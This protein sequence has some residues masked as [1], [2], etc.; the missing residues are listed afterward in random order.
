MSETPEPIIYQVK[1]VLL[2][3]SPM[4]WRR[5]LVCGDSTITDLHF[6]LQI[7]MGWSVD[8]LHRFRIHGKQYGIARMG[9]LSF[10]DAPEN[11]RLKSFRF[12]I[13]YYFLYEYDFNDRWQHQIRVETILTHEP[14][15]AYP[16]CTGG[17]RACPPEDYGGP[18]R[19][20]ALRQPYSFFHITRRLLEIIEDGGTKDHDEELDDLRYRFC[21]DRFDCKAINH[22]LKDYTGGKQIWF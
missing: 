15:R 4:I 14:H 20:M 1:V 9:G 8:H 18:L 21:V 12:R 16:V 10:S 22:R 3:I 5:L 11:V 13:Y 19:F 7:A 6:A 2:G 17:K